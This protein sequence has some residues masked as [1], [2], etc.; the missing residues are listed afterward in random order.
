MIAVQTSSLYTHFTCFNTKNV[1]FLLTQTS[2]VFIFSHNNE[3]I[4]TL[5]Y[6]KFKCYW[7]AVTE[8]KKHKKVSIERD[9]PFA[10]K[11]WTKN[12]LFL[13]PQLSLK[14]KTTTNQ[15]RRGCLV[16]PEITP[17]IERSL[18][19]LIEIVRNHDLLDN[20]FSASCSFNA[21]GIYW[22]KCQFHSIWI[23]SETFVVVKSL[24]I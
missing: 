9:C 10:V 12:R 24:K 7:A 4:M 8:K 14:S 15:E 5:K 23:N 11:F 1:N 2:K 6:N 19:K 20:Y 21:N 13:R 18:Y 17:I 3:H 22:E 16:Y